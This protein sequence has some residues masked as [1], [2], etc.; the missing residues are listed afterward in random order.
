MALRLVVDDEVERCPLAAWDGDPE[1]CRWCAAPAR[2]GSEWCSLVCEDR[3][4]AEHEWGHAYAATLARDHD[5]CSDCGTGPASA[6]EA[7]IFIRA[8]IPLDPMTA[9]GLWR[10][11]EWLALQLS[12]SV[13]VVHRRPPAQSYRSGCHNHLDGLRT[14]C[15][16]CQDRVRTTI[17]LRTG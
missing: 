7:R 3:F 17:D 15:R 10:S 9:A 16:R 5:R 4:Q 14:L 8:M 12:C 2:P 6:G 13:D 1:H 11:E